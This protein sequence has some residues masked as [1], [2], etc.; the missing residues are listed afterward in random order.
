MAKEVAQLRG[1]RVVYFLA[2]GLA[3]LHLW[4]NS[5]GII[6]GLT[7]N[8][9]H[10]SG[11]ILLCSLLHPRGT[12]YL[13]WL[14]TAFALA[15]AIGAIYLIFAQDM[16]YDRGVK[17]ATLDWF[18]GSLVIV[19][20]VEFTRRA[21]GWIIPVLIVLSLSYI[22]WWGDLI[23]G[24]FRFGGLSLETTL[25]RSLFGDDALFGAIARLSA[26]FVFMFILF[27]AFLLR[28][29]AGDF[30][31]HLSRMIAG[32][33][34]GGPGIVAVIASG[35]TGTISG[36]AIANTAST[37]VITIP[38]MK[39]AGF[40]AKFAAAVEAAA[41]TGGQLMP[42]IM[43]AG[44]F[45][46]ASYTQ[47]SYATIVAVSFIPALLY[48]FSLVF[49]VRFEAF[50]RGLTLPEN[51]GPPFWPL[52]LE[53]G[54]AF[55]IPVGL[56]ISM[57]I[58]G[59]TPV[60][61]G[62]LAILAVIISSWFMPVKM[63]LRAILD[64]LALGA[65]NMVITAVLLC[66]VGLI[67]NVIATAGIGNTFSLMIAQWAGHSLFL[68]ILLVAF[69]SLVLGMG[70]P[71]TASYIVLATLSAP[72]LFA[73]MANV[74]MAQALVAGGYDEGVKAIIMLA[75]PESLSLLEQINFEQ[76]V[77]LLTTM[78]GETVALLRPMLINEA[79]L[80]LILL[81]AH[82]IIFWLSQDSNVTPPVCLCAF[83]AAT[84]AKTPPMATGLTSW[85]IAKALYI[86]PLLFAFTPILTGTWV[87]TLEVGFFS[88]LGLYAYTSAMIGWH[89]IKL[90]LPLRLL[91]SIA[92]LGLLW[93]A[94]R[95]VH[96][97]FTA[98]LIAMVVWFTQKARQRRD[99]KSTVKVA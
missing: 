71:V 73:L 12:G 77:G 75:S 34:V 37:G 54:L 43:G 17:L 58:M 91:M 78:P 13:R 27:G 26:T 11:F 21:T 99:S 49:Y 31:I 93:P 72:A 65:R 67:V 63:G 51:A 24:V 42:P 1:N 3:A 4:F 64:A 18:I 85:M 62:A 92:A 55:I 45:V 98:L 80:T 2:A 87:Q 88:L 96:L 15:V 90:N 95:S 74:D 83:T 57:L 94:D 16:I 70:L 97:F 28:S 79:Q 20:A 19:G 56:L 36:S 60:Y 9:I 32:K 89:R 76:A 68:A 50:R 38:M 22:T 53:E 6:D 29:G 35:L 86:I 46:M 8:I 10:F 5:F 82:M 59:F 33:L 52:L 48:F 40:P 66:T 7:L 61:A 69:A 47:I 41:S 14:D 84:I 39:R 25:F 44:A 23:S 81:A 30:V